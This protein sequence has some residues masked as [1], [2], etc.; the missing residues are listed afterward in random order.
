[1]TWER[2]GPV[3]RWGADGASGIS[4]VI[5]PASSQDSP[6]SQ[7]VQPSDQVPGLDPALYP[8][9]SIHWPGLPT[10]PQELRLARL[11][12]QLHELGPRAVFELLREVLGAHAIADDTL[13][14]LERYAKLD[15]VTVALVGAR[16]IPRPPL[17]E[18]SL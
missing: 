3:K 5:K 12:D 8:I 15:P 14:R 11:A 7:P 4:R 18:V 6:P 1:M 2:R 16:D 10:P 9:L 13:E 17:H